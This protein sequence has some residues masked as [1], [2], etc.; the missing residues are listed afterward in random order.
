MEP[1]RCIIDQ[2]IKPK[3]ATDSR[4]DLNDSTLLQYGILQNPITA[5]QLTD[6]MKTYSDK[7][8]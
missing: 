3:L 1:Y 5:K 4:V 7:R 6:L 2:L 8:R